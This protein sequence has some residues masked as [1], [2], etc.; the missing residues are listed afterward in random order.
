MHEGTENK[1]PPNFSRSVAF[2][3]YLC[4]VFESSA[5][6]ALYRRLEWLSVFFTPLYLQ[7]TAKLTTAFDTQQT[8]DGLA[9]CLAKSSVSLYVEVKDS[10]KL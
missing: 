7:Q 6:L 8:F 3:M 9:L 1:E 4:S 10:P 2:A 5:L